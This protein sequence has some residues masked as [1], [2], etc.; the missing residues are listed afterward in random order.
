MGKTIGEMELTKQ[1]GSRA[2]SMPDIAETV[3][4]EITKDVPK[5]SQSSKS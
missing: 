3:S 4:Q 5:L 1:S 2:I